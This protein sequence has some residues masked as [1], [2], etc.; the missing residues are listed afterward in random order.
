MFWVLLLLSGLGIGIF[1][2]GKYSVLASI[3]GLLLKLD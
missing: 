3:L 1:I 2:L